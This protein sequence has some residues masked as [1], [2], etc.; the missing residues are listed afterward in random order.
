MTRKVQ[1]TP[2]SLTS[3]QAKMSIVVVGLFLV[4]G[5]VFGFVVLQESSGSEPGQELL[6]GAFFVIWS[7]ACLSMIVFLAR[8]L[9]NRKD[10][11][12]NSVVD[13]YIEAPPNRP[14]TASGDFE[15]RLRKLAKLQKDGLI[16]DEEYRVKRA[17]ILADKW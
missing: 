13:L 3:L 9:S 12:G 1:V 5:L 4:F 14:M 2:G 15:S 7:V 6:I 11:A 10:P 16:T 17:Q 8:M